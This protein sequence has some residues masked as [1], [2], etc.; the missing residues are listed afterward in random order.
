M[1]FSVIISGSIFMDYLPLY[2]TKAV[3]NETQY[4]ENIPAADLNEII[5]CMLWISN[6]S[7]K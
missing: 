2:G 3:C 4:I 1:P 6:Q 5:P 7:I